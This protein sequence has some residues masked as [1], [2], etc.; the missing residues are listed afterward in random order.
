VAVSDELRVL[1]QGIMTLRHV[2]DAVLLPKLKE[3]FQQF[4]ISEVVVGLPLNMDGSYGDAAIRAREFAAKLK[5]TLILPVTLV[6]ERLSTV[7]VDEMQRL[8]WHNRSRRRRQLREDPGQDA[9]A[10][11]VILQRYLDGER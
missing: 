11:A 1:A 4:E 5:E 2:E 6:D 3:I 8:S 7:E 9:Y 10:A